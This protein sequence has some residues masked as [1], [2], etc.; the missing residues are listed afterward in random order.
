MISCIFVLY[1]AATQPAAPDP[2]ALYARREDLNAARAAMQVWA[3]RLANAT[4]DP[5]FE[6]AWKLARTAYWVGTH[7]ETR[8]IRRAALDQGRRDP[9]DTSGAP[10]TWARSPNRLVSAWD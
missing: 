3:Q 2:D 6:S 9:K 1:M 10:P 5:D 4:P 8:A 7:G